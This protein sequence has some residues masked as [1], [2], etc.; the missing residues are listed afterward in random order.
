MSLCRCRCG[1]VGTWVPQATW[2]S[3]RMAAFF[4]IKYDWDRLAARSIWAFG[5]TA[6]GPNVFLDDT[7]PADVDKSRVHAVKDSIV[8]VGGSAM[9]GWL[10][11]SS[12]RAV[13]CQIWFYVAVAAT[14][15][16]YVCACM[17]VCLC[18]LCGC[19]PFCMHAF[20]CLRAYVV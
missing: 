4:H 8:Q 19:R 12:H 14:V 3:K 1:C 17:H 2:D 6:K 20:V 15:C 13:S 9:Y 11:R 5:P 18:A 7:L 16:A 10:C